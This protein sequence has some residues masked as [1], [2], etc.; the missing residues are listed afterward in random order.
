[1]SYHITGWMSSAKKSNSR[2]AHWMPT[3]ALNSPKNHNC[4]SSKT[5]LQYQ[6]FNFF[7]VFLASLLFFLKL[8]LT[9]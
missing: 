6:G 8:Y 3:L 1:M 5:Y 4:S 2:A 9:V 7:R